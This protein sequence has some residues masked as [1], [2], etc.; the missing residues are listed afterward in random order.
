[1][2]LDTLKRDRPSLMPL[3]VWH[4]YRRLDAGT[5]AAPRSELVALVSLIRHA[6]DMDAHLQ[7]FDA[8]VRENFQRWVMRRHQGNAPKFSE[9]QMEFLRMIR[10]HVATS[11][12]IARDDF[13]YTPFDAK[14][15][16]A[17]MYDLFG[18]DMDTLLD[19]LNEELVASVFV[20]KDV[21]FT[22]SCG[23]S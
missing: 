5:P 9:E 14:G 12:H 17:R 3:H 16:L 2:V 18:D 13:D 8:K 1:E 23:L 6:C 22:V 15:G 10:D 19:E 4:A 21:A 20:N 11:F 7:P